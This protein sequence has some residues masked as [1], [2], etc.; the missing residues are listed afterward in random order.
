MSNTPIRWVRTQ[1]SLYGMRMNGGSLFMPHESSN[2]S[3]VHGA[4]NGIV[5]DH[6]MGNHNFDRD[7]N[8]KGKIVVVADPSEMAKPSGFGKVDTWFLKEAATHPKTG[9]KQTGLHVGSAMV[10]APKGT[11]PIEGAQMRFYDGTAE[12]RNRLVN[13]YLISEG[14]K[15][16]RMND[17]MWLESEFG[18]ANLAASVYPDLNREDLAAGKDVVRLEGGG[19]MSLRPC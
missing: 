16:Q 3:T 15:P 2:R 19:A 14:V 11:P 18:S 6:T 7:G 5:A 9:Q 12:D 13:E 1:D 4:L 17:H 8:L 10:F